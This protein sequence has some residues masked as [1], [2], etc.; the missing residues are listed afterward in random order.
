M[1]IPCQALIKRRCNDYPKWSRGFCE[2]QILEAQ[3]IF[4][5]NKDN[6]IV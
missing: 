2:I 3:S 5:F 6:D 1:I 4:R